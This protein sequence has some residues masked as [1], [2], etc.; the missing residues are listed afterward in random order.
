MFSSNKIPKNLIA[1]VLS[2]SLLAI[3]NA[4][5]F[6][7]MSSLIEFLWKNVYFVSFT[8]KDSLLALNHSPI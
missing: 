2:I 3:F 4:G 5:S 6:R 7:G 8:F 1:F